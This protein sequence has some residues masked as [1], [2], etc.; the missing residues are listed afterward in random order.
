MFTKLLSR[1]KAL[2]SRYSNKWTLIALIILGLFLVFAIG[3]AVISRGADVGDTSDVVRSV[4]V[5]PAAQASSFFSVLETTGEVKSQTQGDLRAQRAG[6]ITSVNAQVGQEVG[7]GRIIASIENASERASV[8]QAQAGVTQAQANLNKVAGGTREEQLAVLRANTQSAQTALAETYVSV[9]N[10][11]LLAYT[12]T[13]TALVGGVDVMFNDADSANPQVSFT[14]VNNGARISAENARLSAQAIVERHASISLR[15]IPNA[16][17]SILTELNR[18][19]SE[20]LALKGL[21]DNLITAIDGAVENTS[22]S[23]TTIASYKT[24]AASARTSVLSTLSTLS[25]ARSTLNSAET[26]LTVAQENEEQG[27]VGSQQEDIDV[28]QAQL[29]SARA[30]LAQAVAGLEET[31][32]RAPVSGTITVLTIELGDFVTAFQDVGIVAN[33]EALEVQTFVSP[34]V[35]DRLRVGGAARIADRHNG[36]IVSIAPGVD[37]TRRQIEVRVGIVDDAPLVHGTRT[38]VEFLETTEVATEV[39]SD[40]RI[41]I[42]ALKLIGDAAFVFTV[43]NGLL[44]AQPVELGAVVQSTVE[45][46][47]GITP[48]TMVVV[49]ARGLNEGDTVTIQE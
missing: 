14:S 48:S 43:E 27:V 20:M 42:S 7:A 30:T 24:T 33:E 19:E 32:V 8:A 13:D 36:V 11:L 29:D 40:I 16:T 3:K 1:T 12:A 34:T 23:T 35:I 21:L 6:I 17:Q 37:P 39:L 41:P 31:R 28:S 46:K 5:A 49:D 10:T 26:A 25:T 4:A 38:R 18:V 9:K 47:S 44:V 15:S 22:V 45:I 2:I